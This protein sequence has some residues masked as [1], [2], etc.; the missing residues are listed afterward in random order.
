[1]SLAHLG[2]VIDWHNRMI[3]LLCE[4]VQDTLQRHHDF[5]RAVQ[6]DFALVLEVDDLTWP[7]HSP[8]TP[9]VVRDPS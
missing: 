5:F 1:M 8:A 4:I 9:C 2:D 7:P 3:I 6:Y